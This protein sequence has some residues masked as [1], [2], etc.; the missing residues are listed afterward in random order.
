MPTTFSINDHFCS[1]NDGIDYNMYINYACYSVCPPS[2]YAV[3]AYLV[4]VASAELFSS[5]PDKAIF[6][7]KT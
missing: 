4:K 7:S 2:N 1:A 3:G 5:L 6:F